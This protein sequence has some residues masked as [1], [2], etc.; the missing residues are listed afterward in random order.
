VN[1]AINDTDLAK[2]PAAYRLGVA[3]GLLFSPEE[4]PTITARNMHQ[5]LE[6]CGPVTDD[7]DDIGTII[8]RVISARPPGWLPGEDPENRDLVWFVEQSVPG[9]PASEQAAWAGLARHIRGW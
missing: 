8:E 5:A 9:R 4:L 3:A 7:A 6:I 2:W 1:A